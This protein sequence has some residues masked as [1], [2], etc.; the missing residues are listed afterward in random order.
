MFNR[1][2]VEAFAMPSWDQLC[3]GAK[4]DLAE[5]GRWH[6][7]ALK[8]I[9]EVEHTGGNPQ[10]AYTLLAAAIT[11]RYWLNYPGRKARLDQLRP[12]ARSAIDEV[13]EKFLTSMK[14]HNK[15]GVFNFEMEMIIGYAARRGAD[16]I[17]ID[18]W[19]PF[20]DI[21]C[22]LWG[23]GSNSD[24]KPSEIENDYVVY[25]NIWKR[26]Q[27]RVDK[28]YSM[29]VLRLRSKRWFAKVHT[30]LHAPSVP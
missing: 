2:I 26:Y 25:K 11:A 27:Y 24:E 30:T 3:L 1:Y 6:A 15:N 8:A 5:G 29:R 19:R 9:E 10:D 12:M 23:L 7:R 13:K 22:D 28:G 18:D 21:F 4:P 14:L 20:T 16:A 17:T